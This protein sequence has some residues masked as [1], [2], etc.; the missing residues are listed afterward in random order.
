MS[1]ATAPPRLWPQTTV[2]FPVPMS[3]SAACTWPDTAVG[4]GL[5]AAGGPS[6]RAPRSSRTRSKCGDRARLPFRERR[7]RRARRRRPRS[8][9]CPWR[10]RRSSAPGRTRGAP[11]RRGCRPGLRYASADSACEVPRGVAAIAGVR[12]VG[13]LGA[14][15]AV[16]EHRGGRVRAERGARGGLRVGRNRRRQEAE[17]HERRARARR[18][19]RRFSS[20]RSRIRLTRSRSVVGG[21]WSTIPS[22]TAIEAPREHAADR[23]GSSRALLESGF[24]IGDQLS[25]A[26]FP[27]H[28]RTT[29][30][31]APVSAGSSL[32]MRAP[33]AHSDAGELRD[34]IAAVRIRPAP[35]GG[36]PSH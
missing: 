26:P 6:R 13:P 28:A 21:A 5:E 14:H 35:R 18:P 10:D 12:R 30:I 4:G 17:V 36:T 15:D 9:A 20:V 25:G 33:R 23:G 29:S 34:Q 32:G 31:C 11:P 1:S 27:I 19:F 3:A 24:P 16:L 2:S 8:P 22:P 7:R